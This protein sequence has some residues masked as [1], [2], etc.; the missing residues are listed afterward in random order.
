MTTTIPYVVGANKHTPLIQ[1]EKS[2]LNF[3]LCEEYADLILLCIEEIKDELLEKPPIK[4]RGKNCS[5]T[6]RCRVHFQ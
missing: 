6:A 3:Y 2:F 5:S 4:M 1:T